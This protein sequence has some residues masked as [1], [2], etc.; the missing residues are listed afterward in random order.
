VDDVGTLRAA[1]LPAPT[2][3][4]GLRPVEAPERE[5]GPIAAPVLTAP[6]GPISG[7]LE[8][9]IARQMRKN[10]GAIER[11]VALAVSRNPQATGDVELQVRW[12]RHA[13]EATIGGDSVGDADLDRCLKDAA[14]TFK[15]SL[16]EATFPWTVH[17]GGLRAAPR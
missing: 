1:E 3:P 13:A 11:C 4:V 7:A 8:E 5:H 2:P 9:V 14:R 16:D 15:L 17:V 6:A 12:A 10:A